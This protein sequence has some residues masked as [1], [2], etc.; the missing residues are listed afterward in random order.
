MQGD[1]LSATVCTRRGDAR[2]PESPAMFNEC[3]LGFEGPR[4]SPIS[5]VLQVEY[6]IAPVRLPEPGIAVGREAPGRDPD[7]QAACCGDRRTGRFSRH[8]SAASVPGEAANGPKNHSGADRGGRH[9]AHHWH[10]AARRGSPRSR[11]L[12]RSSVPPPHRTTPARATGGTRQAPRTVDSARAQFIGACRR[13]R[14]GVPNSSH[15]SAL[16]GQPVRFLRVHRPQIR[17]LV[18]PRRLRRRLRAAPGGAG[19]DRG[20]PDMGN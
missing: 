1:R 2:R 3:P 13:L 15:C 14:P 11:R 17:R 19:T 12:R 9:A 5:G 4:R 8:A 6:G 7:V 10:R 18:H 16:D 20:Q